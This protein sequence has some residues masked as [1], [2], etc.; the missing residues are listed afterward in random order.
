MMSHFFNCSFPMVK[1]F[2]DVFLEEA[3]C[4]GNMKRARKLIHDTKHFSIWF[5][6]S[7]FN[8]YMI[9]GQLDYMQ[10]RLMEFK[11]K[12]L[13]SKIIKCKICYHECVLIYYHFQKYFILNNTNIIKYKR[14]YLS[15]RKY[16]AFVDKKC[17]NSFTLRWLTDLEDLRH[18]EYNC[19]GVLRDYRFPLRK[20]NLTIVG[21]A[22][23]KNETILF[24]FS[25][26]R[27]VPIIYLQ[28]LLYLFIYQTS[29]LS[30]EIKCYIFFQIILLNKNASTM[31]KF[32]T[33]SLSKKH[34]IIARRT[35]NWAL[36]NRNKDNKSKEMI[37]TMITNREK[38]KNLLSEILCFN[39]KRN[40]GET[41]NK[42]KCCS[43]CC[44]AYYCSKHCQKRHWVHHK[45]RCDRK[46]ERVKHI[47][48]F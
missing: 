3:I 23:T 28:H 43:A 7:L 12:F 36:K 48:K 25:D 16:D 24:E 22:G 6:R 34:Y 30:T 19:I 33:F 2:S 21:N 40:S 37:K 44:A 42:M 1:T 26:P 31:S 39:C 29:S 13:D 38:S 35:A 20:R 32:S 46:F 47:L 18:L 8:Y 17:E 11:Q 9:K 14:L 5:Y 41:K 45:M 15:L 27:R 10:K 4:K